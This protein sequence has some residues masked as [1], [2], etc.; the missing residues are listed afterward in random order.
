MKGKLTIT[1]NWQVSKALQMR[2]HEDLHEAAKDRAFEMIQDGYH[3]GELHHSIGDTDY[4]GW[5]SL[6]EE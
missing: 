4:S 6:S 2:H 5:W 1:Y 3:S